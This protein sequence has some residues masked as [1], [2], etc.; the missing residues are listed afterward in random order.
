MEQASSNLVLTLEREIARNV[1]LVDLCLEGV[2]EAMSQPGLGQASPEFRHHALFSRKAAPK[3]LGSVLLLDR[4]GTVVENSVS[5]QP[6]RVN[7]GDRDYFRAHQERSDV[8]LFVSRTYSSRV[9]DGDLSIAVSRRLAAADRSF[10]GVIMGSL[11][12]HHKPA[13]DRRNVAGAV[14]AHPG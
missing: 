7:M 4:D 12:L 5:V 14:S 3:E 1:E 2:Q 9:R 13:Q 6:L 8:G 11:R 10:A